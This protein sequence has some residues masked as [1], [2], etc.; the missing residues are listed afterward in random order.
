[1][2]KVYSGPWS[3]EPECRY[4]PQKYGV[5]Y[6]MIRKQEEALQNYEN[7]LQN[8]NLKWQALVAPTGPGPR[9]AEAGHG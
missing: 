7:A 9:R 4:H 8:S 3:S 2:A 1:M 6:D 5:V